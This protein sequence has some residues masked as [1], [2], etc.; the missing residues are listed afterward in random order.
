M[1]LAPKRKQKNDF[2]AYSFCHWTQELSC[3]N[4]VKCSFSIK[5]SFNSSFETIKTGRTCMVDSWDLFLMWWVAVWTLKSIPC[6]HFL[7]RLCGFQC[8][9]VAPTSRIFYQRF[10][11][12]DEISMIHLSSF[13]FFAFHFE[14]SSY[15]QLTER[16]SA[17]FHNLHVLTATMSLIK[18]YV[19]V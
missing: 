7:V 16:W 12:A 15:R 10:L 11:T 17:G 2:P 4:V 13:Y 9:M 6:L 19:Y 14:M 5:F 18:D 8:K 3:W 1:A